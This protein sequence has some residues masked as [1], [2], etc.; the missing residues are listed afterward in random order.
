MLN[1]LVPPLL[2]SFLLLIFFLFSCLRSELIALIAPTCCWLNLTCRGAR[3]LMHTLLCREDILNLSLLHT[4]PA[5]TELHSIW[6]FREKNI[7]IYSEREKLAKQKIW[8]HKECF[9]KKHYNFHPLMAS[10]FQCELSDTNPALHPAD[11]IKSFG[12]GV[13]G[14]GFS[15]FETFKKL[16]V[17]T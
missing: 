2:L 14:V 9:F 6:Q 17:L 4:N 1:S 12:E 11:Q 5:E 13:L 8:F 16:W 7:R 3:A 15:C 10:F